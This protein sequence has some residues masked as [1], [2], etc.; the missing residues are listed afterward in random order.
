MFSKTKFVAFISSPQGIFVIIAVFF[1]LLFLIITPPF[2]EPDGYEHF[3]R[4]YSISEGQLLA[5]NISVPQA[6]YDLVVN[7]SPDPLPGNFPNKQSKQALL[8]QFQQPFN[9]VTPV[10]VDFIATSYTSL[11][12]YIPQLVGLM[13]GR[14]F[15]PPAIILFY[16]ARL[17]NFA[18]W[19]LG[20]TLAVKIT[21][22]FK[23]VFVLVA[24]MPMTLFMG[25]S[26]SPDGLLIAA[27]FLWIAKVFQVSFQ[28]ERKF[29]I[30]DGI[31]LGGLIMLIA[32]LKPGYVALVLLVFFIPK[33][34]FKSS[35]QRLGLTVLMISFALIPSV[36]WQLILT[37]TMGRFSAFNADP[38]AQLQNV[39]H[40][41]M[42]FIG[43]LFTNLFTQSIKYFHSFA[44]VLGW[45]DTPLPGYV[46][47]LFACALVLVPLFDHTE[48]IRVPLWCRVS[49]A[50][51]SLFLM[52]G[53]MTGLYISITPLGALDLEGFQGRYL[54]PF[55][56]L[57]LLIFYNLRISFSRRYLWM[58]GLFSAFAL[59]V[60]LRVLLT[61]YYA[62]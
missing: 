56:P 43:I 24:L 8:E 7:V 61:R 10:E 3:M 58:V 5:E 9:D 12:A 13:F 23:W 15:N 51:F 35:I 1:G 6:V 20:I 31:F 48:G 62:I 39:L 2:Q 53:L 25:A 17:F 59:V 30:L 16:L 21:P 54:I 27:C 55:A 40:A 38:A 47:I 44:G 19:V 14:L 29:V 22:I 11:F 42:S 57:A 41:P 45:L 34:H 32:L 52:L 28:A 36:L 46:Y 60:A 18:V 49:A 4:I 37:N 33:A 50:V 26:I